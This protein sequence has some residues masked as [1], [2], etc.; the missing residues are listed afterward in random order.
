[1]PARITVCYPDRPAA[2]CLL[3]EQAQYRLGRSLRCELTLNHPTVSREHARV[4]FRSGQWE[5]KDQHSQ[6]GVKVNGTR[7][8]ESTLNGDALITLGELDCLFEPQSEQQ[9]ESL[10]AHNQWRLD[11]AQ[12][13]RQA[14]MDSLQQTLDEQLNAVISLVGTQR[15]LILL[16]EAPQQMRLVSVQGMSTAELGDSGFEGSIGAIGRV[17]DTEA[18]V[19]AMDVTQDHLLNRRESIQRKQIAALVAMPLKCGD[20][21]LGVLYTDSREAGKI[22]TELDMAIVNSLCQ[23][24]ELNLQAIQISQQVAS[25]QQLL[26]S[27]TRMSLQRVPQASMSKQSDQSL[28]WRLVH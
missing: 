25:L 21:L 20:Q 4:A 9:L 10:V 24:I 22:L 1:M 7:V 12:Q 26:Q 3:N 14:E 13:P 5:L 15:G 27:D 6:N 11:Q 16:G 18:S 19:L 23:Q 8:E 2:E 17:I 28:S